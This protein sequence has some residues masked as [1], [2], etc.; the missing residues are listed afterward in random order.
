MNVKNNFSKAMLI[1]MFALIASPVFA[2]DSSSDASKQA[3]SA[4]PGFFS[5]A[6]ATGKE[7]VLT[8]GASVLAAG[9]YLV[10]ADGAWNPFASQNTWKAVMKDWYTRG[11]QTFV[12]AVIVKLGYSKY[13]AWNAET[14]EDFSSSNYNN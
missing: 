1:A 3:P 5:K 10:V 8:A 11:S 4:T 14:D 13:Q 2:D 7:G 9:K 12:A 6:W